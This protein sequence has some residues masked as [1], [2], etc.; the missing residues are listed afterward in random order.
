MKTILIIPTTQFIG[1]YL[2]LFQ[3]INFGVL[4]YNFS[5]TLKENWF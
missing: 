4:N 3:L 1:N 2:A 5:K